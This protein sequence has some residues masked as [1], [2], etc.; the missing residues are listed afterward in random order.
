MDSDTNKLDN[1]KFSIVGV[2]HYLQGLVRDGAFSARDISI[3][4]RLDSQK[5]TITCAGYVLL[6][7]L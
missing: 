1:P 2:P 7:P 5:T 4:Y 3:S 6:L